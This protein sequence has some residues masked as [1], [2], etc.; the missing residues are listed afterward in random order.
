MKKL[1]KYYDNRWM[2][3]LFFAISFIIYFLYYLFLGELD[4]ILDSFI[5]KFAFLP[6]YVIFTSLLLD[7]LLT[8]REHKINER[9][10]NMII[11]V[12]YTEVGKQLL[13][14]LSAFCH[15]IQDV[16]KQL[17]ITDKWTVQSFQLAKA[18]IRSTNFEIG[19]TCSLDEVHELLINKRDFLVQLLQ[20]PNL[21]EDQSFT[22]LL[23]ATFHLSEELIHRTASCE[24]SESDIEHLAG[25]IKRIYRHLIVEWLNYLE[26]LNRNY[27]FLFSL[28]VQVSPF[29]SKS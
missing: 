5:L 9:K 22:N 13:T 19:V 14:L 3:L 20:N 28:E 11:G 26:H 17:V 15:N 16:D 23:L 2:I 10:K 7:S 29:N 25:D 6:I 27:P 1:K 4:Y 24:L 21:L 12:F 8:Q 18:K